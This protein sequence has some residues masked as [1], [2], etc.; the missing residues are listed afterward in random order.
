MKTK[1]AMDPAAAFPDAQRQPDDAALQAALDRAAPPVEA[2]LANL[3]SAQPAVVTAWQFSERSGWYMLL[4]LRKRRLLYLVPK[5]DDVRVMMILGRKAIAQ[6]QEGPFAKQT[7]KLLKT[8]KRYPEGTAF[9]FD[10]KSLKPE[11]LAAFLAAK[12]TH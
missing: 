11:L 8:A 10:R 1:P 6:L 9:S 4:L 12:I 3:R 5:R 7:S 2:I